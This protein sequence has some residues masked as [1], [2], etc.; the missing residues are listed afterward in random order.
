MKSEERV[1]TKTRRRYTDE[2]K[3]EGVFNKQHGER[4]DMELGYTPRK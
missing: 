2:C 4:I 3:A 1:T